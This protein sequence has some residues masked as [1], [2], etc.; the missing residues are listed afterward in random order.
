L[1]RT[2]AGHSAWV[3]AFQA[4][5]ALTGRASST[6]EHC[7]RGPHLR[8]IAGSSRGRR[9]PSGRK[10]LRP[11]YVTSNKQGCTPSVRSPGANRSEC[12]SMRDD[13]GRIVLDTG[14]GFADSR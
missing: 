8:R 11:R 1:S 3:V 12:G 9:A 13:A 4:A 10:L 6:I 2:T 5:C 7:P 14:D